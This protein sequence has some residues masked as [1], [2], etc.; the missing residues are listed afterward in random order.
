MKK[1]RLAFIITLLLAIL[2][3][4][5]VMNR[6]NGNMRQRNN[7]FAVN[8]TSNITRIFFADKGNNTVKLERVAAGTWSI[9]EKYSASTD[10]VN[11]MLK[12]LLALDVKNPVAKNARNTIIRLMAAKSVKV[13]VYQSVFRINLFNWIKLFPHEKRTKTYYVGDATQDNMGTFM[14]MEGSEDPYV[15][16]IP[17]FRGFVSTRYSAIETDWRDHGIFNS[18]LPDIKMVSLQYPDSPQNSFS[19]TNSNNRNFVLTS[20]KDKIPLNDFDTI[21]VIQYLGSF[22]KINFESFL[23]DMEK[24]EYD[25]I[26][27]MPASAVI[28]LEDRF[29]KL[30]VLKVWRRKAEPG[31]TDIEGNPSLWDRDRLYA[32]I[33]GTNDLVTIQYFVFD[34]ILKPITWFTE[35]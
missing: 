10:A 29:G 19:I 35:K 11:I 9:N 22:H 12:T 6:K 28:S 20:L 21:K 26:A 32:R 24:K 31:E 15:V 7:D 5:L 30:F 33:E 1:F 3:I 25:S 16:Y 23:P 17:G 34:R 8:D 27:A 2:A 13:E 18:K 4:I 14:L